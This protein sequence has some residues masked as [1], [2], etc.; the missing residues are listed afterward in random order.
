[1]DP[2]GFSSAELRELRGKDF[3]QVLL[4]AD[5]FTIQA[6]PEPAWVWLRGAALL[7]LAGLAR[8]R[9]VRRPSPRVLAAPGSCLA[10][11]WYRRGV[12]S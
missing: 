6:V 2:D 8:L 1:V 12:E 9:G 4:F 5:A 10:L 7:G 11:E 3:Q